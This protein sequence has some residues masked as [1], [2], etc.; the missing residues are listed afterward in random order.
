MPHVQA[1][2]GWMAGKGGLLGE[3]HSIIDDASQDSV[4]KWEE[5]YVAPGGEVSCCCGL[6]GVVLGSSC[7]CM[8]KATL[9]QYVPT[10]LLSAAARP[11]R[12]HWQ[13]SGHCLT[14]VSSVPHC[15]PQQQAG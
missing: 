11:C 10:P 4:T 6:T 8:I 2:F 12:N 1:V 5:K 13:G 3:E 9:C 15:T 7:R 14:S